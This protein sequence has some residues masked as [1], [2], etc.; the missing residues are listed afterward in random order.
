MK[1][2]ITKIL[3]CVPCFENIEPDCFKS[4]YG[5]IRP[6]NTIIQF[7][8]VR[9]YDCARA[10]NL[11][12]QEAIDYDFDYILMVDSDIVLP[13]D[14]LCNLLSNRKDVV[15][16][17]MKRKRTQT[18]QTEIFT[19]GQKDFT[20]SNNLNIK[21]II[22]SDEP[23]EIKGGGMGCTLINTNVFKTI[24]EKWFKY[25]EYENGAILSEDNY[26]ATMCVKYNYKLFLDTRV[27]CGHINK[28]T[29]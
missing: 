29:I 10:R 2:K 1:E 3:V 25:V 8:F 14:A 4:I 27:H 18:G 7:D 16:G 19:L 20:N 12:A 9:G 26:F 15:Y 28:F 5:L 21:D 22:I 17:W 24:K 6:E 11:M 23:L 13:R